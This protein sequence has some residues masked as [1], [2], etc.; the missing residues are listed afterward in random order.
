L[1]RAA[2]QA[3]KNPVMLDEIVRL[4][5]VLIEDTRFT[6]AGLRPDGIS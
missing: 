2:L 4:H 5:A 1:G 3:G 6:K